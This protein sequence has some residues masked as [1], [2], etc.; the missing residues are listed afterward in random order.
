[1]D[2]RLHLY[3]PKR[4][5]CLLEYTEPPPV[6]QSQNGPKSNVLLFVGGMFDNFRGTSYVDELA[7][8]LRP[9]SWKVCHIQ[10]SS[11][12]RNFGHFNLGRDV[13]EIET[14][15][16][17]IRSTPA[18]GTADSKIVLIGHSTGC[19]DCL[20]YTYSSSK[21]PRPQI[22][23]VILQAAVSDREG[24][25]KAISS[26]PDIKSR[27]DKCFDLISK[28]AKVEQKTTILPMH[29]T[30]PLFGPAPMSIPRFLSLVSPE[31]P[32]N[33]GPDDLFS[34][35][36]PDEQLAKTFGK[37]GSD[38]SPLQQFPRSKKK[39]IMI[40]QAGA[41]QYCSESL[42]KEALLRKWKRAIE[43]GQ[44]DLHAQSQVI[45]HATHDLSGTSPDHVHG[46]SVT[47]RAA[48]MT[49]LNDVLGREST[50]ETA[51]SGLK[52]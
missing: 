19:Q 38:S 33:P 10:L 37:V 2:G 14:C 25:L 32:Q 27:Y 21:S 50:V 42:D 36:L 40:I 3:H 16:D 22:Q 18:I 9:S 4:R 48:V 29:W 26:N 11:A 46:R 35:D 47:F 24:A 41:D 23:G 39:T 6:P 30:T 8:V 17:F 45:P 20:T 52:L 43:L 13:E 44:G 31:S 34:S 1:M 51:M 7:E 49:Y 15:L 28:T 5:L 12:S